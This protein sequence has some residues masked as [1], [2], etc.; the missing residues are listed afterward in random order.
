[1]KKFLVIIF[2]SS[3]MLYNSAALLATNDKDKT[4]PA[5]KAPADQS[6]ISPK[7][8]IPPDYV[9]KL[10]ETKLPALQLSRFPKKRLGRAVL[11]GIGHFIY[12]TSSYWI[13]QDVMKEDWEYQFTWADQKRRFLFID[14]MR[15]DSNTF[16]F[17]WTHAGAGAIYYNYARSNH[18]NPLTSFLY[19]VTASYAWEFFV[20]FKEVVSINDMICTPIG[21]VSIGEAF[22]QLG[23]FFR[24]QKPT[25]LNRIARFASNPILSFS[26]WIDHK[27]YKDTNQYAWTEDYPYDC[28]INLS[29]RFDTLLGND[30]NSY[31]NM[32]IE[33]QFILIPEYGSVGAYSQG[34]NHPFFTQLDVAIS[35][36]TKGVYEFDAYAKSV[37]FGYFKQNIRSATHPDSSNNEI[38]NTSTDDRIGYSFFLGAASAFNLIT[39]DPNRIPSSKNSPDMTQYEYLT[40]KLSIIHLCGP[41]VDFSL[42]HRGLILRLTADAFVDFAL[43]K[44]HAYKKY[45]EL[46]TIGQTK[47]TLQNHG[48]YYGFGLTLASALQL[49]YANFQLKGKA[50]YHYYDSIEGLDRFQKTM[51]PQNDFDLQ[52]QRFSYN[53][54]LGYRLPKTDVQFAIGYDHFNYKGVIENFTQ[55]H[56]EHRMYFQVKYLL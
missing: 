56:G 26:D 5:Q 50:K 55:K 6:Q 20:E 8:P 54:N 24:S 37:F 12:A 19:T 22:F 35:M 27:K 49:D 11:E 2:F 48:Y 10:K 33:S 16:E 14:G 15:F 39:Q 29:P 34:V 36:S 13:R 23:R 43:S 9:K 3:V 30:T 1:M 31:L 51:P 42:Y 21:G 40:D 53:L 38:A 46:H 7:R 47:S 28:S 44:S 45:S 41:T 4:K 25:L 18:L 17:N 32:G 52:D